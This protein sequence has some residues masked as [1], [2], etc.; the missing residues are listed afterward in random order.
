MW[1]A[2][3]NKQSFISMAIHGQSLFRLNY[4]LKMFKWHHMCG[5]WN[6]KTG[7]W[8]LWVRAERVGRGFHNRVCI[9]FFLNSTKHKTKDN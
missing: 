1:I 9:I 3:S 4:P 7:E 8:Q 6:G 5:S 2:N